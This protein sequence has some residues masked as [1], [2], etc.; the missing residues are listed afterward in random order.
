MQGVYV[1]LTVHH[2]ISLCPDGEIVFVNMNG[3]YVAIIKCKHFCL[4]ICPCNSMAHITVALDASS[5]DLNSTFMTGDMISCFQRSAAAPV[6]PT[7]VLE[8]QTSN[9]M[10]TGL[11]RQAWPVFHSFQE[12]MNA[13]PGSSRLA[14]C[15]LLDQKTLRHGRVSNSVAFYKYF[16][17]I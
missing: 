2:H 10:V 1:Y 6:L 8:W 15:Q 11:P 4:W 17:E 16:R 3:M 5:H 7:G 14:F 9:R 13:A 12:L